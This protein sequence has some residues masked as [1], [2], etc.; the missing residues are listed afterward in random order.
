MKRKVVVVVAITLAIAFG[1][2]G[3]ALT[4]AVRTA[5]ATAVQHDRLEPAAADVAVLLDHLADE[6]SGWRGYLTTGRPEL[7]KPPLVASQDISARINQLSAAVAGLGRLSGLVRQ[8]TEAHG[9]WSSHADPA[10]A[11][12]RTENTV[13]IHPAEAAAATNSGLD[14]MRTRLAAIQQEILRHQARLSAQAD[15]AGWQLLAGALGAVFLVFLVVAVMV[16]GVRRSVLAP[17]RG[18]LRAVRELAGGGYDQAVPRDGPAELAELGEGLDAMRLRVLATIG[19]Q[20]PTVTAL[21]DA[22]AASVAEIPGMR[23]ASRIIPAEGLLAG[24]WYDIFELPDGRLGF[25]VGDAAGHG[26]VAGVHA[27]LVKQLLA[28]ALLTGSTPGE[29][30]RWAQRCLGDTGEMFA[31][32]F[33]ATV[34][35]ETGLVEYANAGHPQPVII[36]SPGG[37]RD[38][39]AGDV[40][41]GDVDPGALDPDDLDPDDLD[42]DDLDPGTE[43]EALTAGDGL[44]AGGDGKRG[45][46]KNGAGRAGLVALAPTGPLVATILPAGSGGGSGTWRTERARLAAGDVLCAYSDGITE[47]RDPAGNQFGFRRL[48]DELARIPGRDPGALV[49]D[50]FTVVARHSRGS[51]ADDQIA[52]AVGRDAADVITAPAQRLDGAVYPVENAV[53]AMPKNVTAASGQMARGAASCRFSVSSPTSSPT[54]SPAWP[55]RSAWACHRLARRGTGWF[56]AAGHIITKRVFDASGQFG[57]NIREAGT[58]GAAPQGIQRRRAPARGRGIRGSIT[59]GGSSVLAYVR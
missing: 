43:G 6:D 51:V 21:R 47:A 7:L 49:N 45:D 19:Q 39:R 44:G 40:R 25:T 24:D 31:T 52:V 16:V 58:A 1:C 41:V 55:E 28:A 54:S 23:I 18:L 10:V 27:L 53:T 11:A 2:L 20:G 48:A 32:A 15:G 56:L 46:G 57:A 17:V 26:P 5:D 8:V 50:L 37:E 29:A 38:V 34:D 3:A 9:A 12:V 35:R 33:V 4:A 22:L 42:P 36:R 14:A 30:V 13:V 59:P